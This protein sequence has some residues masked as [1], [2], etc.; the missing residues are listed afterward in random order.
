MIVD[1]VT[2]VRASFAKLKV[3]RLAAGADSAEWCTRAKYASSQTR[4]FP[5][6]SA[7]LCARLARG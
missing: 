5:L 6:K 1:Q 4:D 3:A 2:A 7:R